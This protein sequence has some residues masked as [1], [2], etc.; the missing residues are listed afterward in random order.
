MLHLHQGE[1]R[2]RPHVSEL[3]VNWHITEACNYSCRYCYAKWDGEGKELLHDWGR[4]RKLLDQIQAYFHPANFLNPL[5]RHMSW[6]GVRLNLAGGEPLLY[7]E[8]VLR[9]LRYA[10]AA[11]MGTSII[12]NGSRFDEALMDQMAPLISMLGISLDSANPI[13]NRGIGRAD[14][15][16]VLLDVD[17]AKDMLARARLVN[18]SMRLKLNTVVNAL[19][20]EEDMSLLVRAVRP[21]RWK[22][23]RMLEVVTRELAVSSGQ[24]HAFVARHGAFR[25]VMCVEDNDE[26]SESY[27]MIDPL[28]RFF[29]NTTGRQGYHYSEPIDAIG[30]APA[31]DAWRFAVGSYASRYP[32]IRLELRR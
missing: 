27:I 21:N 2:V 22:I 28:G 4:T 14:N 23:F 30:A 24:F 9:V 26:M 31:F 6:S 19:N 15:R 16:G 20:H 32:T 25:D 7:R 8:Q 1:G 3:V 13:A 12:S 11:G 17:F 10:K 29:Q 5:Q 18:P